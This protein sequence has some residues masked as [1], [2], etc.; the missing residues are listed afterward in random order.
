[1]GAEE[2]RRR[3]QRVR[4]IMK[5]KKEPEPL[6]WEPVRRGLIYCSPGCGADCK[7]VDYDRAWINA[8]KLVE[9]L[10]AAGSGGW[11]AYVHE[12][13]GWFW[14]ARNGSICISPSH[15]AKS[16]EEA[17]FSALI[18]DQICDDNDP[19]GGCYDWHDN[20]SSSDPVKVVRHAIRLVK[21]VTD[22]TIARRTR[23]VREGY[24]AAGLKLLDDRYLPRP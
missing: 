8:N 13:M 17:K 14:R 9:V 7:I 19:V 24:A 21:S 5:K 10:N 11:T 1:L 4:V 12:N 22:E 15:G 16:F 6:S 3:L 23:I 18:S 2:D 20:Y